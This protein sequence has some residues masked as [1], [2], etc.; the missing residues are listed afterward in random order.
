[1][2]PSLHAWGLEGQP[3]VSLLTGSWTR[4]HP[5]AKDCRLLEPQTGG[6]YRDLLKTKLDFRAVQAFISWSWKNGEDLSSWIE[7]VL[8]LSSCTGAGGC[9]P[10]HRR[11]GDSTPLPPTLGGTPCACAALEG[12]GVEERAWPLRAHPL[13]P[14]PARCGGPAQ[15]AERTRPRR[16]Q[17]QVSVETVTRLTWNLISL[18]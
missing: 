3:C 15:R 4:K 12:E 7:N 8:D 9:S 17:F 6:A 18:I 1:M 11:F 5:S 14:A 13:S 16:F 10:R 2:L